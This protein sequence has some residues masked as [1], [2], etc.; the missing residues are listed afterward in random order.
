M[1]NVNLKLKIIAEPKL[2]QKFPKQSLMFWVFLI[3]PFEVPIMP[4]AS[5]IVVPFTIQIFE[6]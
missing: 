5:K 1:Y 4:P 2:T 3:L 6:I